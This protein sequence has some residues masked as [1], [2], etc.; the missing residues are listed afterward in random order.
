MCSSLQELVV[1]DRC[2]QWH[3]VLKKKAFAATYRCYSVA[4]AGRDDLENVSRSESF[5]IY[6]LPYNFQITF[7]ARNAKK[8][9]PPSQSRGT[10]VRGRRSKSQ[11]STKRCT[12]TRKRRS[13]FFRI[14]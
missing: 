14:F 3:G 2:I 13:F 6:D 11:E 8:S 9:G 7:M 5:T 1:A 10:A 4:A 12:N